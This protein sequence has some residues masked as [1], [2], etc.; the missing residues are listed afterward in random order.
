MFTTGAGNSFVSLLAP[1]VKV[2]GNPVATRRL[3]EQ[4]DFDASTV[5][6]RTET[7]ESAAGRLFATLLDVAGGTRTWGEILNEG[8]EVVSRLGPAL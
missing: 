5:A 7:I 6:E 2:S 8:E 3:A 1:T 4:L